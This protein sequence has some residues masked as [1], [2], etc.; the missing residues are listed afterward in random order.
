MAAFLRFK[1]AFTDK[2][3]VMADCHLLTM[4]FFGFFVEIL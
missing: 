1:P 3:E 2:N 4:Y